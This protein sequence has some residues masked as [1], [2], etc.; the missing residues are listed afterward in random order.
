MIVKKTFE[1]CYRTGAVF[2]EVYYSG[3]EGDGITVERRL[4]KKAIA[5][6]IIVFNTSL[7]KFDGAFIRRK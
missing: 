6:R 4:L 5:N 7:K 3:K 1:C 2:C